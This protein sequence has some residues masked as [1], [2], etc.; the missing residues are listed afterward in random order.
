MK[1]FDHQELT[2]EVLNR[3]G[4]TTQAV[5]ATFGNIST[6]IIEDAIIESNIEKAYVF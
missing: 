3:R 6:R 2:E 1:R 5:E 4:Q